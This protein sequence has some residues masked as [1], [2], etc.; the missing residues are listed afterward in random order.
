MPVHLG[1]EDS[2]ECFVVK[3][4]NAENIHM[5]QKSRRDVIPSASRR[6]ESGHQEHIKELKFARVFLVIPMSMINPL[7]NKHSF[8]IALLALNESYLS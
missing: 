4:V 8:M 2:S 3:L 7:K 5:S 6:T 1:G